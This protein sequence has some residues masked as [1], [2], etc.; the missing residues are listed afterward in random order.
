MA[1]PGHTKQYQQVNGANRQRLKHQVLLAD[2]F[3][4]SGIRQLAFRITGLHSGQ[5][6]TKKLAATI[7][8]ILVVWA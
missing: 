1:G 6:L 8:E 7:R 2:A 3:Q 5:G 4:G